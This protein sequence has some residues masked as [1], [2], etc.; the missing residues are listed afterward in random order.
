MNRR[1]GIRIC[2]LFILT[3]LATGAAFA[4]TTGSISGVVHG[5]DGSPLPGVTVTVVGEALPAGRSALTDGEG[6]YKILR[7][8]PGDYE[9]TAD[10]QGMGNVK[11]QAVIAVEVDTQVNLVL[12]PTITEEITV[13]EVFPVIDIRSSEAQVNF[14]RERIEQL[15]LTRSYK[16]LFQLAPGVASNDRLTTPNAG[17][18]RMDNLFL[19]DGITITNPYFGDIVPDISE[20]DIAEVNIK[21]GGVT[22]EFGRTG[23]MVVNAVTK[24]GTNG[25]KGEGRFELQ[26]SSFVADNKSSNL[27][28][29]TERQLPGLSFGGPLLQDRLWFYASG[30]IP[31]VTITDRRNNLG[32]VPDEKTSTDE[33]FG[34]VTANP[35][36]NHF[37]VASYRSRDTTF[38]NFGITSSASPTIGSND[39]T[40]YLLGTLSWTWNTTADSF[41]EVKLNHDQ[42][43]NSTDPKTGLGYRPAFN[44][45][46][47]DLMGQFTTTA[48][49]VVGGATGPGQLV[50]GAVLAI[51]DQD[52]LRDE[53]RATLQ[54]FRAWGRTR[55]DIRTGLTYEDSEERLE[56]RANG[57]GQVTWSPTTRTFTGLYTS[58]QPPHTGRGKSYGAFVQD[59]IT[60]GDR[61]TITAGV[62]VNKDEYFGETVGGAP[63][64]KSKAKILTFDWDQQIQ[65]RLGLA[66]VPSAERGDKIYFNFGRYY[67]TENKSLGRAASPSRIFTTRATFDE[68]GVLLTDVPAANTQNKKIDP[69]VDPQYMD[70]YLAGYALPLGAG[71]SAE[72][73]GMY[74]NSGNIYEDVSAD[75][76]GSGP[77]R[78][79]QLPDAY[80]KYKAVTL[81]ATRRPIDDRWMNLFID[82]SYSW[83]RLSGNWDIDFGGNSPFYNSSFIGDGP[84]ALITDN[85]DGILRGDRTH[86]AKLFASVRPLEP[87]KVGT[88]LRY[89]SGGAWE[90]RGLPSAA[91]T[92]SSYIAYLEKAGSRRMPSWF[93]TD[94]L[95]SYDF[96]LGRF[97]LTVEGKINNVLDEQVELAVDDRYFI[98]R[99][100]PPTTTPSQRASDNPNF[101]KGTVFTPPRA[102]VLSAIVRF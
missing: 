14:T 93:N 61:L 73:W 47:P 33:Y 35:A 63:G 70:E 4:A 50:G 78:V 71:W 95:A 25:F 85:R 9:V 77:F 99:P 46:R 75:G 21:R 101:G 45:A 89:Q 84:G 42:E 15:P 83:N 59:Q 88:Y 18:S 92:S 24:S 66:Y 55:H 34:K 80:R 23:G 86:V 91:V 51:N 90:A 27:Q 28:N 81:Q 56:R 7:L 62:L 32:A 38:E 3:L 44:A 58:A 69:G 79:S 39:S 74:R 54:L 41:V 37:L 82:F 94:L 57:W 97:G 22:A 31:R 40:K 2:S 11:R 48:D 102:Y 1:P 29:T 76:L 60:F 19:V 98:V 49:R 13:Q 6:V 36:S 5:Q 65:P 20:L 12:N 8:P 96:Q 100:V 67:N 64:T 52:Y 16:G 30:Y 68:N 10:V 17:G 26:P 72:V 87:L 53:L 43:E